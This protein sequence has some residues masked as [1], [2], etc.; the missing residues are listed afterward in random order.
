MAYLERNGV[1]PNENWFGS[2]ACIDQYV[3]DKYV[4]QFASGSCGV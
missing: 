2:H 1:P 4:K 3:E